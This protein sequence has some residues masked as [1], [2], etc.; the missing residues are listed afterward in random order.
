MT[1]AAD[2]SLALR[3]LASE[4]G[5]EEARC[6]ARRMAFGCAYGG[7]HAAVAAT[8]APANALARRALDAA[9][10]AAYA[11][12]DAYGGYAVCDPGKIA[13]EF[14]WQAGLLRSLSNNFDNT[15]RRR[16]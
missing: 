4:A 14:S 10:Y 1:A 7:A 11:A 2:L 16:A 9:S 15:T 12:V 6:E 13:T 8:D 3:Q 5:L